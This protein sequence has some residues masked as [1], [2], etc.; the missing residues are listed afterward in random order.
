MLCAQIKINSPLFA[1]P[2][3]KG[4]GTCVEGERGKVALRGERRSHF[5]VF[6]AL[7]ERCWRVFEALPEIVVGMNECEAISAALSVS[8]REEDS[9]SKCQPFGV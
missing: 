7:L 3:I 5:E 4:R 1:T 8:S 9:G 6:T 2:A